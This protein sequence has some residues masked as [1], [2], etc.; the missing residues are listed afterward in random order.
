MYASLRVRGTKIDGANAGRD[1]GL[2]LYVHALKRHVRLAQEVESLEDNAARDDDIGRGNGRDS[3]CPPFAKG[4]RTLDYAELHFGCI[5][6]AKMDEYRVRRPHSLGRGSTLPILVH[7]FVPL[8]SI[9]RGFAALPGTQL[10]LQFEEFMDLDPDWDDNNKQ[11]L[12]VTWGKFVT[13]VGGVGDGG[14]GGVRSSV[15]GFVFGVGLL[16]VGFCGDSPSH[17]IEGPALILSTTL[18]KPPFTPQPSTPPAAPGDNIAEVNAPSAKRVKTNGAAAGSPSK[19]KRLEEAG[20]VLLESATD[21]MVDVDVI[22]IVVVVGA[23]QCGS[24]VCGSCSVIV[25]GVL[26]DS[27]LGDVDFGG[28]TRQ[29]SRGVGVEASRKLCTSTVPNHRAASSLVN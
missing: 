6:V 29:R 9:L 21:G 2:E 4:P 13:V 14:C 10:G 20:L 16:T 8:T 3:C 28:I 19:R 26:F 17:P 24:W 11:T 27:A 23:F 15:S 1:G 18:H 5:I 25:G 12:G 22:K 7:A